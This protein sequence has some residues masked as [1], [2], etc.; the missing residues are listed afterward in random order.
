MD[1]VN[2]YGSLRLTEFLHENV[3]A[4]FCSSCRRIGHRPSNCIF[5]ESSDFIAEV[6]SH[7]EPPTNNISNINSQHDANVHGPNAM[8]SETTASNSSHNPDLMPPL[9]TQQHA[10]SQAPAS[11]MEILG[12]QILG[13]LPP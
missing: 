5:T 2:E 8:H 1:V 10:P 13:I 12:N 6:N 7:V 11:S 3:P 4:I 9:Q